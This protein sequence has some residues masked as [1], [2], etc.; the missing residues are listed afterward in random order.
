MGKRN[1]FE[2]GFIFVRLLVRGN[3]SLFNSFSGR[4]FDS[5]FF[6]FQSAITQSGDPLKVFRGAGASR[7]YACMM[8]RNFWLP[9]RRL[10]WALCFK[11]C[12]LLSFLQ[13]KESGACV[14][15]SPR[16]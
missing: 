8:E 12:N 3:S 10:R 13:G 9:F 16:H 1:Y 2:Q 15:F 14:D 7:H 11:D 4:K 6:L 5:F